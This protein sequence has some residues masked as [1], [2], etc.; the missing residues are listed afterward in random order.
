MTRLS[1]E[2]KVAARFAAALAV[3]AS[4]GVLAYQSATS[5]IRTSDALARSREGPRRCR[6]LTDRSA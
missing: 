3:L 5:F 4:V 1:I 2:T 6:P